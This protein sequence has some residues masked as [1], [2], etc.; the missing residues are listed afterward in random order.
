M[1]AAE[2]T[3]APRG[4]GPPPPSPARLLLT[5][6]YLRLLLLSVLL[7]I[8]VALAAFFFVSLQHWLQHEIWTELPDAVGYT[9]AP[10]WWPLPALALAGLILAPIVT[11]FPGGGGHLP[12]DGLGAGDPI[13]P[14]E[15]PGVVLAA[16]TVL[17]LGGV[18]GPEAPLMAVGS[19]LALL[20]VRRIKGAQN[21]QALGVVATAGSTAAI[22][23]ILGGPI[24][25]AILLLEAAGLGG[26]QLVVLLLPCLAASA[27]G[28]LVFTGFGQWTGLSIGGLSLPSVPPDANPDAGDFLWGIPLAVLI[29]A[30][31]AL[32][33]RLGHG[34]GRWT[35][36][37]RT[38]TRTVACALAVGVCLS[39]YA[40]ITGRSPEEAALSGQAMLGELAAHPGA[41]SVGALFALVACK[42]LAWAISLGGLR[43][44]PIF[45]ALLIG[46]AAAVACAALPGL[47]PTP[48][49]ALGMTAAGTAVMG[50]P[51]CSAVL[52]VLL[53]GKDAHDQMPLIVIT[54]V[55]AH[56]TVTFLNQKTARP[57]T[58]RTD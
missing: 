22:S 53:L 26:A 19:A 24:V 47:G 48:A 21:P 51:L 38:A 2:D 40:L 32:A 14:R 8:P 37:D 50:L 10:W 42:G 45:P 46:A 20:A 7:G 4:D 31:V 57:R 16:L 12:A 11:R 18:L 28:A 15:L 33:R 56:L 30:A 44:G 58:P 5:P 3:A 29:A 6:G 41:W 36:R 35:A 13:G 54:A 52:T 39:A 23:T 27:S 34:T 25:A 1:T 9:E 17:P 49:L 55:T 43:G